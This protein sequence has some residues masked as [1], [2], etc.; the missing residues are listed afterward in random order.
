[1]RIQTGTS[2]KPRQAVKLSLRGGL[3]GEGDWPTD[4]MKRGPYLDPDFYNTIVI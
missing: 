3:G 2:K 4:Q 1:M